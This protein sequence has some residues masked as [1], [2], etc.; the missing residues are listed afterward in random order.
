MGFSKCRV[1]NP[2][3]LLYMFYPFTIT[4]CILDPSSLK[5]IVSS[6]LYIYKSLIDRC[7]FIYPRSFTS[8][9]TNCILHLLYRLHP[10]SLI[11][12]IL[13]MYSITYFVS[14]ILFLYLGGSAGRD[15]YCIFNPS[16]G[17]YFLLWRTERGCKCISP[18]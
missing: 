13:I 7:K 1:L 14:L 2:S 5:L 11:N 3:P 12:C 18:G 17:K 9:S 16:S 10:S 15:I 6:I 4:Y 8:Y